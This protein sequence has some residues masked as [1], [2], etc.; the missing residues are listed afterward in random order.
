MTTNF[1]GM[2]FFSKWKGFRPLLFI[3]FE[4]F[5]LTLIILINQ[6]N[7]IRSLFAIS[8]LGRSWTVTKY[9]IS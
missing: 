7:Y 1:E 4:I 8:G 6:F 5:E 9:Y 3:S 2:F